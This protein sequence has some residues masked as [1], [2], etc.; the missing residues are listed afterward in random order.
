[1]LVPAAVDGTQVLSPM[2]TLHPKMLVAASIMAAM[3]RLPMTMAILM[4]VVVQMVVQMVLMAVETMELASI[5]EIRG[6]LDSDLCFT[7]IDYSLSIAT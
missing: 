2:T 1:M 6:A 7:S 4:A 3:P 5:V